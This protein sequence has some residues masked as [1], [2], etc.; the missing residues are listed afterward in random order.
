[1]ISIKNATDPT[2]NVKTS[3][4]SLK[5]VEHFIAKT[6]EKIKVESGQDEIA[7]VPSQQQ[8]ATEVVSSTAQPVAPARSGSVNSSE[9][10]EVSG[11]RP[12]KPCNCTKSQCLK[13]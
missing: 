8:Q 11:V 3:S 2:S 10:F 5:V 6:N 1:M 13:L 7:V 12:K 9:G 4:S